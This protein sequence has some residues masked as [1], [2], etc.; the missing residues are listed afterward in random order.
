M[1]GGQGYN[2]GQP[3]YNPNQGMAQQPMVNQ[4]PIVQMQIVQTIPTKVRGSVYFGRDSVSTQCKNCHADVQTRVRSHLPCE[5]WCII[6]L[7][8]FLL[9][10]IGLIGFCCVEYQYQHYCPK[11]SAILGGTR[12]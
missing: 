2:N 7:L 9:G 1:Q 10:P 8:I 12:R 11:C 6:I 4:Q 5:S 3:Q